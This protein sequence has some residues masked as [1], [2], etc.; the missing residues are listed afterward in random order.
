M[1]LLVGIILTA[2][3]SFVA[4]LYMPWWS[5]ALTTF[6]VAL[7]I[8]QR[9]WVSWLTGF[10]GVFLLWGLLAWWIDMKNQ[11]I[12]S[13]RIATLIPLGGSGFLLILITALLGAIIGGFGALSGA[14]LRQSH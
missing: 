11:S 7:I 6:L 9:P 4:G 12:L 3:L 5:I 1:K 13:A 14:Y 8:P 10:I 2:L